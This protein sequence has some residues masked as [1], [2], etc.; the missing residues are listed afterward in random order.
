[1]P[2][3]SGSM[4]R[5]VLKMYLSCHWLQAPYGRSNQINEQFMNLF[6]LEI[7]LFLKLFICKFQWKTW[8]HGH[9]YFTVKL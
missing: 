1:M 6:I 2:Q 8:R 5:G 7:I 4:E 9:I 3:E